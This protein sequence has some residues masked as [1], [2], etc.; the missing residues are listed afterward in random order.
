MGI[1]SQTYNAVALLPSHLPVPSPSSRLPI[2][3]PSSSLHPFHYLLL[4]P[5][6]IPLTLHAPSS[7]AC[8]W[9]RSRAQIRVRPRGRCNRPSAY[10]R[11]CCSTAAC[12]G[13]HAS[14]APASLWCC[15]WCS[16]WCCRRRPTQW[17]LFKEGQEPWCA[18]RK[19]RI[20]TSFRSR[21]AE[22]TRFLSQP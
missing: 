4:Y 10:A 9:R 11:P 22:R 17:E 19:V 7:S 2:S 5:K 20:S 14:G 16:R 15:H 18:L 21:T 1:S 12:S 3:S 8:K 6:R 13:S